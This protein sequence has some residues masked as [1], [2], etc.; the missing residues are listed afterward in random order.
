MSLQDSMER[1]GFLMA[2]RRNLRATKMVQM[3]NSGIINR[4][5]PLRSLYPCWAM[6]YFSS[7]LLKSTHPYLSVCYFLLS[8]SLSFHPHACIKNTVN[9][10]ISFTS[11]NW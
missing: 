2:F 8:A 10:I 3:T 5:S 9:N 4:F 6:S 1:K 7:A 11:L